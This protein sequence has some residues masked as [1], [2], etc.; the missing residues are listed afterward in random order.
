[1]ELKDRLKLA[2]K[3]AGLSQSE[4]AERAGIKQASV[5]E[6]E[7]GLSRTSGYLVKIA[8]IC[9]VDPIWLAEGT[10]P[11]GQPSLPALAPAEPPAS[12]SVDQVR[13]MLAKIGNGLSEQARNKI[14]A[15]V[16]EAVSQGDAMP[17]D[18][19]ALRPRTDEIL[20]PQYDIRAAMGH[21][22]VPADYNEAIRNL[23]VREDVLQGK[24][25]SYTSTAALAVITGWGQS[26][27]GTINDK[28][29]VIVDRGINEFIGEGIYV[30]SWH[31]LLYIKRLQM[32]DAEHFWLISD[33]TRHKDQQAR[34]DDVT[35][36]A[37]VLL[38]LNVKKV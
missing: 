3:N 24:G 5:S 21:G 35:I 20:I 16:D 37:K 17:V 38:V 10:A 31:G 13:S 14:L 30:I 9:G 33:N 23:V 32:L 27:E 2:R 1:M 29:P 18:T 34:I 22:Q 8:Q 11:S 12:T 25:V 15:V 19:S 4:L 7:R 36:H 6:I 28:D 26:M